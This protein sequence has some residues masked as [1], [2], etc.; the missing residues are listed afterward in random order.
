GDRSM[1]RHP[2]EQRTVVTEVGRPPVLRRGHDGFDV[3]PHGAEV[4]S[5][6]LRG[7]VEVG[8][9]RVGYRRVLLQNLQVELVRPPGSVP[10]ALGRVRD[11]LGRER[12]AALALYR[13]HV[14]NDSIMVFRHGNCFRYFADLLGL[15][16][17][18]G[19]LCSD[20][21]RAHTPVDD[22]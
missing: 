13:V 16:A 10:G 18:Q 17:G 4:E 7:V 21:F 1:P 15:K 8:A 11:A 9:H 3:T 2:D 20:A 6:E 5:L 22:L 19:L 12:A 14:A